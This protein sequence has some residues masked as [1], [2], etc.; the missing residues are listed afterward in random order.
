M[1]N[2][3]QK[4]RAIQIA[5]AVV[6]GQTRVL[7]AVRAL[8]PILHSEPGLISQ[9]DFNF[10]IGVESET[11]DLPIGRIREEWHSDYLPDKD[12]EIERCENLWRESIRAVCERL[13]L[14]NGQS[15]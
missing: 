7:E 15:Q 9:K 3:S 1:A 13:L 11:D 2:E 8:C 12:H 5:R 14:Q 4:E 10:I 6:A